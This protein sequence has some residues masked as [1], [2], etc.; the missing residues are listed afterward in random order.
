MKA[1]L[2]PGRQEPGGGLQNLVRDMTSNNGLPSMVDKS[3]FALG[4]NLGLLARQG[5]VCRGPS[6]TDPVCAADGPGLPD[7]GLHR[8][9]QINKFYIWDLAPGRS[10][11]EYLVGQGHQVF[12]VSWRNPGGPGRL[13]SRVLRRGPRPRHRRSP[14]RSPARPAQPRRRLL[15]RHHDGAPDRALGRAGREARGELLA[16][17]GGRRR[18]G[19]QGHVDGALRQ[20]RDAGARAPV[21][22]PRAC[23]RAATSNARFH[24][25][26]PTT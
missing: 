14:A 25:C 5:R 26:G 20:S 2:D 6:G 7:S 1:T 23:S 19:R 18:R 21:L 17:R 12:I 11:V 16:A 3:K 8:A 24:G 13:G 9:P 10:I 22:G 15:R 4:Q